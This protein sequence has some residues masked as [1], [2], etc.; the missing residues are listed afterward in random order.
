MSGA[1]LPEILKE[2]GDGGASISQAATIDAILGFSNRTCLSMRRS[3]V[4][5]RESR[6]QSAPTPLA[7]LVR[8]GRRSTFDQYLML[9]TWAG[10]AEPTL[11]LDSRVWVR[12]LGLPSTDASRRTVSRNWKILSTLGL[13]SVRREGRE[14]SATPLCEDGSGRPYTHPDDDHE[15]S[16][17]LHY[18]Y[19]RE[20]YYKRL[21][22]PGKSVLLIALTLGDWFALPT[23]RGPAWYG[24]SRSTLERGFKNAYD[25]AVLGTRYSLKEAPLA[26]AGYTKE[27]HYILLAPFGPRGIVAKTA[28][29][30]YSARWPRPKRM[31]RKRPKRR[32]SGS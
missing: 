24:L 18:A 28:P 23:R 7:A 25:C 1:D 12:I 3:F 26:P 5:D 29:P 13:V 22:V 10:Q 9:L 16:L 27:N 8:S 21:A 30:N 17:Q 4:Q 2:L 15:P 31:P 6:D 11:C 32:R 20:R 14:I 19:W